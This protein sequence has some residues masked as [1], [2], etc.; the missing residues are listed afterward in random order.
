MS[1]VSKSF[2]N[3][4]LTNFSFDNHHFDPYTWS[5]R[6]PP[7][8]QS[9]TSPL[10][11]LPSLCLLSTLTAL[12]PP[13]AQTEGC[14]ECSLRSRNR[15]WSDPSRKRGRSCE[16][17]EETSN[18]YITIPSQAHQTNLAVPPQ[19][20]ILLLPASKSCLSAFYLNA[21]D[22]Y[23]QSLSI[24]YLW[25]YLGF[26]HRDRCY[27]YKNE[28]DAIPCHQSLHSPGRVT[29]PGSPTWKGSEEGGKQR[30]LW[31]QRTGSNP[32]WVWWPGQRRPPGAS[33]SWADL[34]SK[35]YSLQIERR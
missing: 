16:G 7:I 1:L 17:T 5:A 26:W 10:H 14:D 27:G 19:T 13:Q 12:T 8:R 21:N 33:N 11:H 2:F 25:L 9:R 34:R 4:W 28:W 30:E 22:I 29:W 3:H 6:P 20:S 32:A 35:M 24:I 15:T 31:G 18:I 23:Q